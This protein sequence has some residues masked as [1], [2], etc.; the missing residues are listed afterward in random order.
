MLVGDVGGAVGIEF[1]LQASA[2]LKQP[3]RAVARDRATL[4]LA[5]GLQR[6]AT[7]TQPRPAALRTRHELPRIELDLHP[8]LVL[9]LDGLGRPVTLALQTLLGLAQRFAATLARAQPL[10]QL[11]T[12]RVTVELILALVDLGASRRIARA[13][14]R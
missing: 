9:V 1:L 8:I 13:I 7:L 11:V 2:R 14:C 5:L 10:R 6:A 3:L 12:A 4:P